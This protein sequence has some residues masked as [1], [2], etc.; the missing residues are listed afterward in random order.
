[1]SCV[2]PYAYINAK[3]KQV[4]GGGE[5]LHTRPYWD[6]DQLVSTIHEKSPAGPRGGRASMHPVLHVLSATGLLLSSS[7]HATGAEQLSR[8]RA[9]CVIMADAPHL[10][11][12][13]CCLAFLHVPW[14]TVHAFLSPASPCS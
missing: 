12:V 7:S 3:Y 6:V 2:L 13:V 1:M 10:V 11:E 9:P 5:R 14:R 4:C 8:H